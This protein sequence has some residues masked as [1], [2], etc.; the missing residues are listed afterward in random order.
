MLEDLLKYDSLGSKEELLFLL[1][2]ALP[3][4]KNQNVSDLKKYCTSNH[5]SISRSF[6][7]MLK[8]LEFMT[9]ITISDD[10]V[11]INSDLFEPTK[12]DYKHSYL[13]QG[14]F[15]RGLFL[16]LKR[17]GI[18]ADFIRQDAVKFDADSGRY[19]V[20]ESLIPLRFFGI[21]NLLI[22]IGLFERDFL[23]R[24]NNLLVSQISSELF[25]IFVVDSLK[26]EQLTSKRK[27][28]LSELKIQLS[29]QEECGEKAEIFVLK[30]E[31][32][33]LQGHPSVSSIRRVSEDHA[34][35]GFDIESFNDK[36]S[37]FVDRYIEVKSFS[38]N[39]AFYW[40]RH[41]IQIA[42]E[43]MDKYFLYLV[44]RDKFLLTGYVPRMFQNPYQKIF[45][46]EFWKKEPET[47]LVNVMP[48]EFGQGVTL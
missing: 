20:K 1:F 6:A 28:A 11:S 33:R 21:K 32:Q 24:S 30:F 16:S 26:E 29:R 48:V 39:V 23:L 27:I 41:E 42:K 36:K 46:N 47:W 37:V 38:V 43:L 17:E 9:F 40:S 5:F 7:G 22:S 4:S 14:D 13:E 10:I 35:A 12:I 19:Y 44:D 15:I 3:L 31:Q 8:L 2:K 45:E 25:Q 18:I 34:N